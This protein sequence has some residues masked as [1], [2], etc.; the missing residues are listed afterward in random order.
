MVSF[1]AAIGL[2]VGGLGKGL[3]YGID[4]GNK[5][6]KTLDEGKIRD[7]QSEAMDAAQAARKADM[8]KLITQIDS[9]DPSAPSAWAVNGQNYGSREEAEAVA[10]RAVNPMYDYFTQG[11]YGAQVRDEYLAQGDLEGAKRWDDFS[12]S[13]STE[14]ALGSFSRAITDVRGGDWDSAFRNIE[15]GYQ[16]AGAGYK[17]DS[18]DLLKDDAGNVI[19]ANITITNPDGTQSTHTFDSVDDLTDQILALTDPKALVT[20]VQQSAAAATAAQAEL[21]TYGAK[22]EIDTQAH[23]AE[24]AIDS[25]IKAADAAAASGVAVD[26]HRAEAAIDTEAA[27]ATEAGKRALP[28]SQG[29]G[30]S[31]EQKNEL[32]VIERRFGKM[33]MYGN[34]DISSPEA[35]AAIQAY[36]TAQNKP[37]YAR[38]YGGTAAAAPAAAGSDAAPAGS[39]DDQEFETWTLDG[40]IR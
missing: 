13:A 22:S 39:A 21:A 15:R 20:G 11:G 7:A 8:D 28:P 1:G 40:P 4:L 38:L 6:N 31:S 10:G 23:A 26:Q 30:I 19:G 34:V 29:S 33:D 9:A 2:A 24:G 12:K 37:Q 25:G 35:Q 27:I 17:I 5:I 14:A 36:W 18:H 32:S 16:A 3:E